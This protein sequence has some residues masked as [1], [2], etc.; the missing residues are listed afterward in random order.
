M[1]TTYLISLKG[2]TK[3]PLYYKQ[4]PGHNQVTHV[5]TNSS[6]YATK[7]VTKAGAVQEILVKNLKNVIIKRYRVKI[8]LEDVK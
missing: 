7:F 4:Y 5:W 2:Q 1:E 3:P 8:I 6:E